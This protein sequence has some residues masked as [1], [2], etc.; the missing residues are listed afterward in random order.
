MAVN[1]AE[2]VQ[3]SCGCSWKD[4]VIGQR[5]RK[6]APEAERGHLVFF[7]HSSV[8]TSSSPLIGH[9][10]KGDWHL[11]LWIKFRYIRERTY[12]YPLFKKPSLFLAINKKP[13]QTIQIREIS[14]YQLCLELLWFGWKEDTQEHMQSRFWCNSL[15][16]FIS[17]E[18]QTKQRQNEGCC[19]GTPCSCGAGNL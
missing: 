17:P 3:H 19:S 16:I 12:I 2:W 15:F 9:L 8:M 6:S 14:E 4:K 7:I 11:F 18:V 13:S 5:Q 1:M 10:W